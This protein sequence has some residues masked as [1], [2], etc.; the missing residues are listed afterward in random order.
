VSIASSAIK[1]KKILPGKI[2]QFF[3]DKIESKISTKHASN[4]IKSALVN[5]R[6]L[7]FF[8]Q[9]LSSKTP[10]GDGLL[11]THFD[12]G[13]S[14]MRNRLRSAFSVS[15]VILNKIWPRPRTLVSLPLHYP[16]I[17]DAIQ[18]K[19]HKCDP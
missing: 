2:F 1:L 13:R 8:S 19:G 12:E 6:A 11:G 9:I 4:P 10:L 3:S 16:L 18:H 15:L 14:E 7:N 5:L 17:P